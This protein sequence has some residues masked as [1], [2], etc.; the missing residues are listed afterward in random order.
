MVKVSNFIIGLVLVSFIVTGV[1]WFLSDLSTSYDIEYDE[2]ELG[3]YD[4]L[5][6]LSTHTQEIKNETESMQESEGALDVIGSMF[7]QGYQAL[8]VTMKSFGVFNDMSDSAISHANL[9]ERGA[10]IKTFIVTIILILLF[11]GV[12]ISA[13]VKMRI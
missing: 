2:S 12:I 4:K 11:I 5:T 8:K 7:N 10:Y 6:E 1:G 13:I 9:G 3:A